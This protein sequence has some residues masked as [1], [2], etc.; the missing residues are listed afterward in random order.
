MAELSLSRR[1]PGFL[2]DWDLI[3][4]APLPCVGP[5]FAPLLVAGVMTAT[6]GVF[7]WREAVGRPVRPRRL[8]WAAFVAR[9]MTAMV[10][11]WWD[12]R[13]ILAGG[14]LALSTGRCCWPGC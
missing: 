1:E 7:F 5:V 13:N 6:A 4:A 2:L 11:F 10:A 9:G 14:H 12:A 8:H 3:F